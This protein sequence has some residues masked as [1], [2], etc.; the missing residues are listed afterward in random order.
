MSTRLTAILFH[1]LH[2]G[3]YIQTKKPITYATIVVLQE[4]KMIKP[5][6]LLFMF[7]LVTNYSFHSHPLMAQARSLS[8]IPQQSKHQ[9][10]SKISVSNRFYIKLSIC[11]WKLLIDVFSGYPRGFD[12]LGMI[13]K[14]C[15]LPNSDCTSRW[16]G[17]CSDIQCIPWRLHWRMYI[18]IIHV[19]YIEIF[20]GVRIASF[21]ILMYR[22]D[23]F[24]P[25]VTIFYHFHH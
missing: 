15:D 2:F 1:H 14:C 18:F 25:W 4:K 12:T 11:L 22:G 19:S 3:V 20:Y 10:P 23:Y 5:A 6:S 24:F 16:N 13:C 9:R 17:S 8:I 7:L 21:C